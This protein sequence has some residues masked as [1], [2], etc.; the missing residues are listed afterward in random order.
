[1]S[2]SFM[3]VGKFVVAPENRDAFVAVIKDYEANVKQHGLDHSHLIEAENESETFWYVTMW[4]SRTAWELVEEMPEHLDM[5]A[6]R[7]PLLAQPTNQNFGKI[8]L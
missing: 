6:K 5:H 1:M 3:H 4:Q 2:T 8:I 7:D